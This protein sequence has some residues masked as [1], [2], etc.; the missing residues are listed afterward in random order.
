MR[1]NRLLTLNIKFTIPPVHQDR[2]GKS[3]GR[4]VKK[5]FA[6][7]PAQG[8]AF[9]ADT[10]AKISTSTDAV[11]VAANTDVVIEA[12]VENIGIK[13]KLFKALDEA[14]PSH[15]IFTSNTSSLPI[16]EIAQGAWEEEGFRTETPGK[17][18]KRERKGER[19]RG[20]EREGEVTKTVR[21][22]LRGGE[23]DWG[24]RRS[25]RVS[26]RPLCLNDQTRFWVIS[27]HLS[28]ILCVVKHFQ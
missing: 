9:M 7:D 24:V 2:I 26:V 3:L 13:Q 28:K 1:Q 27:D 16:T 6:A 14:A 4:V 23:I 19:E 12:I 22:Y 17:E 18:R 21:V 5:K 20:R 15:T 11:A 25:G 10:L 8:E